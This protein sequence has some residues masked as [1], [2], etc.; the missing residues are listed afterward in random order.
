MILGV[1]MTKGPKG[2]PPE[3]RNMVIESALGSS[4][5]LDLPN[6]FWRGLSNLFMGIN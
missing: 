6:P 3:R 2:K 5:Q 4:R 1:P